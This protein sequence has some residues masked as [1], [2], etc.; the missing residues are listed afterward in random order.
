MEIFK[1]HA[2]HSEDEADNSSSSKVNPFERK[3]AVIKEIIN[4]VVASFEDNLDRKNC[5]NK[6]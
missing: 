4:S 2:N 5:K 3:D 6:R 1:K